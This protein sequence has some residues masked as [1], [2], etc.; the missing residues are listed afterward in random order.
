MQKVLVKMPFSSQPCLPAGVTW[1]VQFLQ[2]FG[3]L[4]NIVPSKLGLTNGGLA[5][6]A[7]LRVDKTTPGTKEAAQCSNRGTCD[8]VFGR[9]SC[10]LNFDTSN[11]YG[12]VGTR[13]DCG[14]PTS[15]IQFC[16]G[17]VSCSGHGECS[18]AP[19]YTCSCQV[20]W[21]AGDCSER[22]DYITEHTSPN[23]ITEHISFP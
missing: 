18:G 19:K 6:N 5:A 8:T 13:G 4:P 14:N 16:P 20:G 10:S 17:A 21:T 3:T 11:G 9:C 12:L 7:V 15:T 23:Y 2:Q 22:F 1:T